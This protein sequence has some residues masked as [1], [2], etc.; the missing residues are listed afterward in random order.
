MRASALAGLLALGLFAAGLASVW[1]GR[2]GLFLLLAFAALALLAAVVAR[3]SPALA[4]R[5]APV[6]VPP[7]EIELTEGPVAACMRCGSIDVRLARL[8]EGGIPGGGSGL[9]MICG[10]C[11]HRGPPL[12]FDDPT[13]YRQF[14]KGLH[15]DREE[16]DAAA[17]PPPPS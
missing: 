16:R 12:E 2:P 13:A 8:S 3:R 10:R 7:E 5:L 9:T 14:I 15:A 4:P 11:R 17:R 1:M 6:D